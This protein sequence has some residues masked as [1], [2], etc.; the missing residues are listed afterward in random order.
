MLKLSIPA[1]IALVSF[2]SLKRF[3]ISLIMFS[4]YFPL[5]YVMKKVNFFRKTKVYY[6]L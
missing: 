2:S 4:S 5:I 1:L 3:I 6:I